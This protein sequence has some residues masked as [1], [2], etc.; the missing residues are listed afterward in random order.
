MFWRVFSLPQKLSLQPQ[1][2][3]PKVFPLRKMLFPKIR[4][5]FFQGTT[6]SKMDGAEKIT[7]SVMNSTTYSLSFCNSNVFSVQKI[8][9]RIYQIM[10]L[11]Q[12]GMITVI[13]NCPSIFYDPLSLLAP[14][15]K[16]MRCFFGLKRA[17]HILLRIEK[18]REAIPLLPGQLAPIGAI[19]CAPAFCISNNTNT[20]KVM[21]SF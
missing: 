3:Y 1:V 18:K 19:Y 4:A 10:A 16:R 5:S 20:N 15:H 11:Y 2:V 12:L 14:Q 8:V 13:V 21:L 6:F 17:C 7:S 9:K